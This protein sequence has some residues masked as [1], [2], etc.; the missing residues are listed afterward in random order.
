MSQALDP[1]VKSQIEDTIANHRV[2]LFM[3]GNKMFPQCGFSAAVVGILKELGVTFETK[4]VLTDAGLRD[5]IK[6][7]SDWPT[8]PQLYVNGEFVGGCDIVRE[9]HANGELAKVLGVQPP[10]PP[11]P[12]KVSITAAAAKAFTDAAE[13]G[14]DKL[15]LEIDSA[16][17]VDLFFGPPKAGDIEVTAGGIAML[18][19][20][21]S[22]RRADGVSIDYVDGP[23]GAGFQI[24]NPNAPA[25]P[26]PLTSSELKVM[27]DEKKPFHLFDVRSEKERATAKIEGSILLDDEGKAA[28]EKLPKDATIVFH[29]HHGIR[30]QSAAEHYAQQGWS[31]TFNLTGGIDAWSRLVD[32]SVPRY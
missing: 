17:R 9:M 27:M 23:D 7:F 32:T 12:P 31:K 11:P 14:P 18:I 16:F 24:E 8:I 19:D 29:C 15:R 22:A 21:A 4:N 3:K 2:V 6:L 26:K 13:P 25:R 5:G 20:P 30:S 1:A 10:A 28:L